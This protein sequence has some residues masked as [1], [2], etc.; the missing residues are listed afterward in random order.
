MENIDFV[1]IYREYR[2]KVID[3]AETVLH[4]RNEAEDVWQDV[5]EILY[6]MGETADF[7]DDV[8]LNKL[9]TRMSFNKALDYY[10]RAFRKYEYVDSDELMAI[11]ELKVQSGGNV[12]EII[13]ALETEGYLKTIFHRLREKKR[14]DYEIYVSVS[15]YV[16][17]SRLVAEHYHITEN[18]VNNKVMR[19][20]RWLAREYK[21]IFG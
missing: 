3:I 13:L 6:N 4:D 21:K 2:T 5:F 14:I 18:N 8:K 1:N 15:L 20:R 7:S 9:I 19:T 17:R 16:I 12:D 10:K 11:A